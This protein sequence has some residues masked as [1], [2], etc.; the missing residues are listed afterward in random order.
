MRASFAQEDARL[1]IQVQ[2]LDSVRPQRARGDS[3]RSSRLPHRI[4]S[5]SKCKPRA[6]SGMNAPAQRTQYLLI[7]PLDATQSMFMY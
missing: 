3:L 7:F 2:L 1:E 6:F 4:L 5:E